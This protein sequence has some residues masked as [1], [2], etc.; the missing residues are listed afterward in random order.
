MLTTILLL[1]LIAVL[2][3][4][5]LSQRNADK[6]KSAKETEALKAIAP[7]VY[8]NSYQVDNPFVD[9]YDYVRVHEV[10][11]GWVRYTYTR[12]ANPPPY[13]TM[14][15]MKAEHFTEQYSSYSFD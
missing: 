12:E 7:G 9:D 4:L 11:D 6:I 10:K 3:I 1:I 8:I 15:S 2:A 13:A 5:I 14:R